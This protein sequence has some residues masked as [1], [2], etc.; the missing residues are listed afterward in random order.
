VAGRQGWRGVAT[1]PKRGEEADL[2]RG[3]R[4]RGEAEDSSMRRV[5]HEKDDGKGVERFHNSTTGH[6]VEWPFQMTV[7][8]HVNP[9]LTITTSL[10]SSIRK[11]TKIEKSISTN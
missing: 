9:S 1:K 2:K 7:P 5:E 11:T 3:D 4:G 6:T 10:S 8:F